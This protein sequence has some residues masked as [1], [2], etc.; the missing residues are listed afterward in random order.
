L[1]LISLDKNLGC[2]GGFYEG[3][4]TAMQKEYDFVWLMDDDAEPETDALEIILKNQKEGYSAYAPA[5]YAGSKD[6][7]TINIAGHRGYF[8]FDNP[9]PM[10]QKPISKELY[11]K[12]YVEIDMA[13]FVGIF[14]PTLYIK[15]IGLPNKELFIHYDDT[16][17]CL[18]LSKIGKILMITDSKIYHKDKRQEEKYTKKFLWFEKTRVRYD[19]LWI[20]YFG[21]RN[22]IYL[23]IRYG[24][25]KASVYKEILKNYLI[26]IKDI[27]LYDDKKLI[28]IKFATSSY[29]DGIRGIFDNEKPS[30]ILK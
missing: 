7:H 22:A 11:N 1:F 16:E 6:D 13:S 12:K 26:L 21:V 15:K 2:A 30:R 14:I 9:L 27:I 5:I 17:Y 18:R 23:A 20:K 28:R 8:D 25:S 4:K 10:L 19:K 24:N 3:V 29:I